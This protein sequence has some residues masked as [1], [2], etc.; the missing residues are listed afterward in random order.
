MGRL[1]QRAQPRDVRGEGGRD[2][3]ALGLG[4]Q[5]FDRAHD[6]G[7]GPAVMRREHV[8]RVANQRF[9][10]IVADGPERGRIPG[11]AHQGR[12]VQFQVACMH[13]APRRRVDDQCR[14]LG[15]RVRDGNEADA[16]RPHLD[17]FGPG[18]R[19]ADDLGVL[20]GPF[21]LLLGDQRG[22]A[23]GID[24]GLKA[25]PQVPQRADVVLVRVGDD[26][27][28]QTVGTLGDEARVGHDKVDARRPVH[29]REGD[30]GVHQD[31]PLVP[32]RPIAVEVHVHADL[33]CPAKR[34][35]GKLD[36]FAHT[37]SVAFGLLRAWISTSP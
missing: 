21:K 4:H 1:R 24:R 34:Q 31:E 8:G 14:R 11:L 37:V 17:R 19:D 33:A 3:H 2:D 9:H 23:A 15:D 25:R 27:G 5:C 16:E 10:A 6:V 36:I 7:F 20:P 18:G 35:V 28:F 13:D 12:L 22:E 29:V 32:D 26:D 30:A